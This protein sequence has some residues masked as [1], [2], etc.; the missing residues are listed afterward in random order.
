M[1]YL[2][3]YMT[4]LSVSININF[5]VSFIEHRAISKFFHSGWKYTHEMIQ[6]TLLQLTLL[7]I[8]LT[9]ANMKNLK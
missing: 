2:F 4:N 8:Q 3:I 9:L 5:G 6:L 7:L 1:T